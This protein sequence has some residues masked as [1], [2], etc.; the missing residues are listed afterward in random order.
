MNLFI[1]LES[2]LNFEGT[3]VRLQ[4]GVW[5]PGIPY[6]ISIPSEGRIHPTVWFLFP[7]NLT[8]FN[9]F[10]NFPCLNA[11]IVVFM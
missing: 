3:I 10:Q 11:Y 7:L 5:N 8:I 1:E 4:N 9:K 6:A 2:F